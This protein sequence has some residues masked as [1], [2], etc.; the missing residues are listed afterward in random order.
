MTGSIFAHLEFFIVWNEVMYQTL[1]ES[2]TDV[3]CFNSYI[4]EVEEKNMI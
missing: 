4:Y 1:C 3:N 2:Q